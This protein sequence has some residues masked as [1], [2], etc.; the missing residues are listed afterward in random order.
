MPGSG[1]PADT[2]AGCRDRLEALIGFLEGS[3]AAAMAHAELE[4]RVALDGREVLRLA[5]QG[6]LDMRAEREQ[7]SEEVCDAEGVPRRSAEP[8]HQRLLATVFGE[9]IVAR[10]AY[11]RRGHANLHPA[12]GALNL[13]VE[14]YS[15][16]LRELA[17]I[18]AA[19]GSFD[20]AVEA[21]CRSTGQAVGK[22]QVE[23]L[24]TRAAADFE[25]LLC[26]LAPLRRRRPR[27]GRAVR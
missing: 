11:R 5:L 23:E 15:H 13:P 3:G 14:R 22:R 8:G 27:R 9:V 1:P 17:G 7:R 6:H 25:D 4:E 2:F 18:E 16:G 19:R 26:R 12:D 21:I 24:A 10:L 20:G